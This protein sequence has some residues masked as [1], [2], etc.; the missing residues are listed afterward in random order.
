MRQREISLVQ[1]LDFCDGRTQNFFFTFAKTPASHSLPHKS[2]ELATVI[3]L[4]SGR[5][6]QAAACPMHMLSSAS[7]SLSSAHS[8]LEGMEGMA[9]EGSSASDSTL[10][11]FQQ[12]A[13]TTANTTINADTPWT[14]IAQDDC[15]DHD[16]QC[17]HEAGDVGYDAATIAMLMQWI[18]QQPSS[19]AFSVDLEDDPNAA[20]NGGHG[21]SSSDNYNGNPSLFHSEDSATL[22][23]EMLASFA[24]HNK[25]QQVKSACVNCRKACK[26]CE[27]Q[28]PCQRCVRLGMG[29]TCVSWTRKPREKGFR[30]GPYRKNPS[31]DHPPRQQQHSD[32]SGKS[33]FAAVP[34][35][36]GLSSAL[37]AVKQDCPASTMVVKS[38]ILVAS[39]HPIS[40]MEQDLIGMQ[41]DYSIPVITVEHY[42]EEDDGDI[43]DIQQ[44]L[45]LLLD[46]DPIVEDNLHGSSPPM[47]VGARMST[48]HRSEQ[49]GHGHNYRSKYAAS[50]QEQAKQTK[51]MQSM[52]ESKRFSSDS[53]WSEVLFVPMYSGAA[54]PSSPTFGV[55]P[56]EPVVGTGKP[57]SMLVA[58]FGEK[59]PE[60]ALNLPQWTEESR[61][62]PTLES[63]VPSPRGRSSSD[64]SILKETTIPPLMV[65][66]DILGEFVDVAW[67][68]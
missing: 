60:P 61:L 6:A 19:L 33:S 2:T 67:L 34:V 41:R 40:L 38:E 65:E 39:E 20:A 54:K 14:P 58:T 27:E 43:G 25:R 8:S 7:S 45:D 3:P 57:E 63:R 64:I 53:E 1:E 48:V 29:E 22:S 42:G 62:S 11:L 15:C 30:R 50:Q 36:G 32:G 5:F 28:R 23:S 56:S 46:V 31:Q 21:T 66:D 17:S 49:E 26:K 37:V 59:H 51:L 68:L 55:K 13:A 18:Q 52:G 24:Q 10:D 16:Q 47:V 35:R 12:W 4:S 9:D 44:C